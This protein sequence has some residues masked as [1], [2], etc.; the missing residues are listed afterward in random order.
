MQFKTETKIN[1]E[2]KTE[3]EIK[4]D[5]ETESNTMKAY[6]KMRALDRAT[7]DAEAQLRREKAAARKQSIETLRR[8][9]AQ[10]VSTATVVIDD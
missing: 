3:T 9:A 2:I 5:T 1:T 4:T 8:L 7:A 6:M 10:R